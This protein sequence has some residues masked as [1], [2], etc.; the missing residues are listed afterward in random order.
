MRNYIYAIICA[1]PR[2]WDGGGDHDLWGEYAD[3][4]SRLFA[5]A[6]EARAAARDLARRD[7]W[8]LDDGTPCVPTF[9]VEKVSVYEYL[10]DEESHSDEEIERVLD[11]AGGSIRFD[12]MPTPVARFLIR[13]F[14]GC[15]AT[16]SRRSAATAGASSATHTYAFAAARVAA[17]VDELVGLLRSRGA[18]TV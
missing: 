1:D 11:L 16:Y 15:A 6:S 4:A 9:S 3:E 7:C 8:R 12:R 17:R 2:G 18:E 10:W 5:K 13:K 14:S